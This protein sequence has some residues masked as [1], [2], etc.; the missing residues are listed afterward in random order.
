[1]SAQPV[2]PT[3]TSAVL[4][5]LWDSYA[6]GRFSVARSQVSPQPLA[7]PP[8]QPVAEPFAESVSVATPQ[9]E[10]DQ[11]V[12]SD[13]ALD[14]A[15]A[16]IENLHSRRPIQAVE[17][18]DQAVAP[19]VDEPQIQVR[20]QDSVQAQT[21]TQIQTQP[22]EPLQPQ[23]DPQIP[24]QAF[25][26]AVDQAYQDQQA[27]SAQLSQSGAASRKESSA[28]N[29]AST[30]DS[31]SAIDGSGGGASDTALELGAT[32]AANATE[33]GA[34]IQYVEQ[35]RNPELPVEVEG[36][37]Q[38]VE[39]NFDQAPEEIVLADLEEPQPLPT[40]V[41]KQSVVVLPITPDQEKVAAR[42]GTKFSV[43]WLVEW[44][45]KIM[46]IFEG[47]VVYRVSDSEK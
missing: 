29:V 20:P 5:K 17:V 23:V 21:Q 46:K 36:F 25:P 47:S 27:Q 1:M 15:D 18:A 22:L 13:F 2:T 39:D 19:A 30:L 35:E 40:K 24:A 10:S 11:L 34:N 32:T 3:K 41:P 44:S 9:T 33:V 28:A 31:A 4:S 8:A 37:L 38:H 43:K 14:T 42:K 16:I 6:R 12:P 26:V 45:R 7:Q